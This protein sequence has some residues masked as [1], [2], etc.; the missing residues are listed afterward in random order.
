[1][2]VQN[3]E[4]VAGVNRTL[5]LEEFFSGRTR[6]YGQIWSGENLKR[7][8]V[9]D[10]TGTTADT[11]LILDETFTFDDGQ[12]VRRQW[13][14]DRI[15]AKNLRA[16][17]DD[18]DDGATGEESGNAVRWQYKM[19]LEKFTGSGMSITFDDW[20]FRMTDDVVLNRARLTKLGIPFGEMVVVFKKNRV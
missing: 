13:R 17:A 16:H 5:G 11:K 19:T 7:Q 18:V 12:E 15:D 9:V 20:M 8:F 4:P 1:M 6:G 10:I 2:D 3:V 14:I